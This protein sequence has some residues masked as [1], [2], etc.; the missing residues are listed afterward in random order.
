[1]KD[2]RTL[3]LAYRPVSAEALEKYVRLKQLELAGRPPI[4]AL[5]EAGLATDDVTR[6][7]SAV[8]LFCR[9]RVL[10]RRLARAAPKSAE[11]KLKQAE[12]LAAPIDDGDFLE[13]YGQE[14]WE[15]LHARE[16]ELVRLREPSE[17]LITRGPRP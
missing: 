3:K 7:A 10:R 14:S 5:R 9:P 15:V 17:S 4:D 6:I 11:R 1:M 13:L 2:A 12:V 8:N 16:D